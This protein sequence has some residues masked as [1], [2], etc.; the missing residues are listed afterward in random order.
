[1]TKNKKHSRSGT[2]SQK[3]VF[4]FVHRLYSSGYLTGTQATGAGVDPARSTVHDCLN[5]LYIGLPSTVGSPV[6]SGETL[7]PEGYAFAANIAFC[8]TLHLLKLS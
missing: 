5:T 1:M 7:I 8:H 3:A 6:G 4:L 2:Q